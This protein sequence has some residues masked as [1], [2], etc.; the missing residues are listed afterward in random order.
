M[1]KPRIFP[2][3]CKCWNIKKKEKGENLRERPLSEI[4]S[5]RLAVTQRLAVI[6]IENFN[7]VQVWMR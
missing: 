6:Q 4:D 2:R 7:C 3:F 1:P 5:R